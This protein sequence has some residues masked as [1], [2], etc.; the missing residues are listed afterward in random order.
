M[1]SLKVRTM[2]PCRTCLS[3]MKKIKT[4]KVESENRKDA[5]EEVREKVL[6]WKESLKNQDCK[7]CKS[8]KETK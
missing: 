6:I 2:V 3:S 5:I 1:N 8:I 4:M 7:I